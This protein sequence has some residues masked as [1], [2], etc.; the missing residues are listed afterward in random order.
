MK[1]LQFQVEK[2]GKNVTVIRNVIRKLKKTALMY[3]ND[4][5]GCKKR[6]PKYK[7]SYSKAGSKA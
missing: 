4:R 2:G 5:T 7:K 6:L 3:I 1:Q